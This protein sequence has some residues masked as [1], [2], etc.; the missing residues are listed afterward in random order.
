M[1]IRPVLCAALLAGCAAADPCAGTPMGVRIVDDPAPLAADPWQAGTPAE[2]GFDAA[3]LD[4][5]GAYSESIGG[6]CL[7]VYRKGK[8]VYE[9][10]AHGASPTTL[11]KSWSI[12][13]SVTSTLVG[14]AVGRGQLHCVEQPVADVVP[15]WRDGKH[16][17]IRVRQLLSHTSGLEFNQYDD[18]VYAIA[19]DDL[20]AEAL[21]AP[22]AAPPDT[23]FGYSQRSVQVLGAVLAGATGE[24]AE[25]YARRHLWDPLGASAGITWDHDPAGRVP[26]FDGLHVTCRD[27]L[28]FGLLYL[29]DGAWNGGRILPAEYARAATQPSQAVNRA[30]GYLWWLNGQTPTIVAPQ[31]P[32]DGVLMPGVPAEIFSATG[33]GQ[34]FVDV[35]R[36]TQTVYVHMRPAP[37]DMPNAMQL[38]LPTEILRDGKQQEHR[39][40]LL[41]IGAAER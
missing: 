3:G 29:D 31:E 34:N 9:K 1:A 7:L 27:L 6:E 14:I 40:L 21:R 26:M 33:L 22:V 19:S 37:Q 2:V 38:D 15:A 25:G 18:A 12:A 5:A 4:A 32:I 17:D 28:R 13:K 39:E 41:R 8:L 16:D 20:T 10:Y 35:A 24:E 11:Q 36:S 30:V 23:V